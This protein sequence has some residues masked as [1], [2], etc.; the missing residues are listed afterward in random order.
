[1]GRKWY[2]FPDEE[3]LDMRLCDLPLR[4]AGTNLE[5]RTSRLFEELSRRGIRFRPHVWLAEEWFTP[6]GIPGIAIP[7]YLAHP[8]LVKLER[9]FMLKAEGASEQECMRILRHEAGHALDNAYLLH[10]RRRW[11]ELFGPYAQAYPDSYRPR[12]NSR[13]F[14][15]HLDGWYAQAHPAEDFAE[16]FA[17]WLTPRYPWRRRYANWPALEKLE[18]V[19]SLMQEISGQPP[20]NRLRRQVEPLSESRVTLR[21]H[22]RRKREYY[23][24]ECPAYYD[25]DLRRL[26]LAQATR[27]SHPPAAAFVR[28]HRRE[29]CE[30][31]ARATG[32]H[33]YT[34]DHVVENIMERCRRL[35]LRVATSRRKARE[36]VLLMLTVHTMHIAHAGY[37]RM[38]V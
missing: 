1:V 18:Y 19:D 13:R 3:L 35:K 4:I 32:V 11:R 24:L 30:Q 6:D 14:V 8:R 17:V 29:L 12:P 23:A 15:L 22:Y 21:E 31:V 26:F 10:N 5:E 2:Q 33:P 25:R 16:T 37:F 27:R 20:R 9:K 7:F 38:A 28:S 36:Q 34:I